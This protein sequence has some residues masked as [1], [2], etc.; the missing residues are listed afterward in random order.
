MHR[1]CPPQAC[2]WLLA[3]LAALLCAFAPAGVS[4]QNAAE[5]KPPAEKPAEQP[6]EQ[7]AEK[8]AEAQPPAEQPAEQPADTATNPA[9][10]TP[11]PN[12]ADKPAKAGDAAEAP[13]PS[14]N[15]AEASAPAEPP[16]EIPGIVPE[17]PK[18]DLPGMPVPNAAE[19]RAAGGAGNTA[20]GAN[21]ELLKEAEPPAPP[22]ELPSPDEFAGSAAEYQP[23]TMSLSVPQ[24]HPVP[25]GAD[26]NAYQQPL[27][28]YLKNRPLP[29]LDETETDEELIARNIEESLKLI[30]LPAE[31]RPAD[32]IKIPLP[33]GTV[34]FKAAQ[35][36][37]FDR[38]NRKLTFTGDAEIIFNDI[39]IWADMIEV[40]D[41]AAMAYAKGYVAVQQR[42]DIIYCDEAYL[43]YDTRA[44]ELFYIEGNTGGPRMQGT[45]YFKAQR[46]YGTFDHLIMEIAEITTCDPFC[47][48]V[49]E[50]HLS[51]HKVHYKRGKSI[52]MHGVHA[53][54][55][56]HKVAYVPLLAVP[57]PRERHYEQQ[58]SEIQQNYGYSR[59]DGAFA[60]FAY[61]YSSRYVDGVQQPLKGVI[62]LD[63]TQKRGGGFGVRQDFYMPALGVTTLRGYYQ[64]DWPWSTAKLADG[65]RAKPEQDFEFELS[66][67]LNFSRYLTGSF[68]L[69]RKNRVVPSVNPNASGTRTNTW[70]SR[71]RL[72]YRKGNTTAALNATQRIDVRGGNTRSDG[73][74]EPVRENITNNGTFNFS[75]NFRKDLQFQ[76]NNQYTSTKGATGRENLP[77][78]QEGSFDMQ[79][80]WTGERDSAV[81]G[82]AATLSYREQGI[83]YDR[84]RNTTDNNVQVRK[85][86]PSLEITLPRDLFNDGAYFTDFKLN[87]DN[88]VTGRRRAPESSFRSHIGIGGRDRVQFSR[89]SNLDTSLS[90]DQFWYDDGNAQYVLSPRVSYSYDSFTWWRFD[91]GWNLTY[92]QGVRNP[93]VQGD[94]RTYQQGANYGFT[95]T[96][97]HSWRWRLSGGYNFA[98][99]RHNPVTSNFSWDPNR[100]FGM[101]HTVSYDIERKR[102]TPSR[103]TA[104]LRSPYTDEQGWPNWVVRATLDNDIEKSWRTTLFN[105]TY[106]RR[107]ERGW[108]TE[109]TGS[110]RDG[111]DDAPFELNEDFFKE[112]IKK[113]V[114][115]KVNCCTTLEAGWRTGINEIYLNVY[116]N[117]LPQYPGT[118]D[119][120][121]PFD[122]EVDTQFLFPVQSLQGDIMED[123]FGIR[124]TGIGG[125]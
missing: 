120:R 119:A 62:K 11:G 118:F 55:R 103:L 21:P 90:F 122:D 61:T 40:D 64:Q 63:I 81:D 82:Y 111:T 95:F 87:F 97:R 50:Y 53:Y 52:V 58:E 107:Y 1:G 123:M 101:T 35:A 39:A 45:L 27:R 38:R 44:L 26:P 67:E 91:A 18:L 98:D 32:G 48:S 100:V 43:N 112:F 71:F 104:Q 96:N 20:E 13:A 23:P 72:D 117:A 116:L 47:G 8:E 37:Q 34:T 16:A 83:D 22:F 60:K 85:E 106:F 7:P 10:P 14:V 68:E 3:V 2:A 9:S 74:Q 42:D 5:A 73:T 121:R 49:D 80:K 51:S 105:L 99:W 46:A 12:S 19:G 93:P 4:A 36:F 92:R 102:F 70:D 15:G 30:N 41:A 89:G 6:A 17:M 110:F 69:Q 88:L 25:P 114:V 24:L 79:L 57:I 109:I 94:R 77:A 108:S 29:P 31:Q 66:Q 113:V 56:S 125:F 124:G 75:K 86:L 84:E 78:D 28:E 33:S 65:S 115:R 59:L 76:L 54:V